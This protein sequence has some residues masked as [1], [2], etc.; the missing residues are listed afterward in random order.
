MIPRGHL[1]ALLLPLVIS[2][3]ALAGSAANRSSAR[4]PTVLSEREAGAAFRTEDRTIGELWLAW[5]EPAGPP[6]AWLPVA[7]LQALGFDTSI[8]PSDPEAD[9]H[10][11]RQLQRRAFVAFELDGPAYAAAAAARADAVRGQPPIEREPFP[12]RESRLVPVAVMR[13]A[14]PLVERFPDPRTHLIVRA[15][16][17]IRR[18]QLSAGMPYVGGIVAA[19][20]PRRI[21]VP[22]ELAARLPLQDR[23]RRLTPFSVSLMYGSRWEPWVTDLRPAGASQ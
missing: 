2:G 20:E 11:R 17:G 19:V 7:E 8:D 13:D 4:G 6:G 3:G 16:V 1:L 22:P 21:Q 10:Y 9:V 23:S 12:L 18:F 15:S 14:A 5:S